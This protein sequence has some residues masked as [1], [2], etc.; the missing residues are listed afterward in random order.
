MG[1]RPRRAALIAAA[2]VVACSLVAIAQQTGWQANP[3]V[4]ARTAKSQ[5][6]SNFEEARVG[7][8][9]L[10]DPLQLDGQPVRSV[11]GWRARR[12]QILDLFRDNVYGRAPGRPR[13]GSS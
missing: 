12:A 7:T 11:E 10:P 5:T 2:A 6:A 4:V 13:A 1:A 3:E 8:F 9:T